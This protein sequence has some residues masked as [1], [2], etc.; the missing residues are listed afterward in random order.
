MIEAIYHWPEHRFVYLRIAKCYS[1]TLLNHLHVNDGKSAKL[2]VIPEDPGMVFMPIR[3]PIDRVMSYY[4]RS[5]YRLSFD[6]F[7]AEL[8]GMIESGDVHVTPYAEA[9]EDATHVLPVEYMPQWWGY[10]YTKKPGIFGDYPAR[11][12]NQSKDKYRPTEAVKQYF[13]GAISH[14]YGADLEVWS[15]SV[16]EHERTTSFPVGDRT[17]LP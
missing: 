14:Y 6:Q 17:D 4:S 1:S 13:R 11:K 9:A 12:A 8:P 16:E 7:V 10:M 15:E 2:S 3:H 5:H